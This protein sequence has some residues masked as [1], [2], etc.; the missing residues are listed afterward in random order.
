MNNIYAFNGKQLTSNHFKI[1][2]LG[3][4]DVIFVLYISL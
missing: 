2:S 1:S 4:F 3:F